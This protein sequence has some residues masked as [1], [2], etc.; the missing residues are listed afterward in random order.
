VLH[1]DINAQPQFGINAEFEGRS[2]TSFGVDVFWSK[3]YGEIPY[4]LG[5][6]YT[7]M[8]EKYQYNNVGKFDISG[9]GIDTKF[10][11]ALSDLNNTKHQ[12]KIFIGP[13]F[14]FQWGQNNSLQ[15]NSTLCGS[16]CNL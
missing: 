15:Y 9:I 10:K 8:D 4:K 6:P 11:Y 7:S 3:V 2:R 14:L 1:Y 13:S 5:V 12:F 16:Q